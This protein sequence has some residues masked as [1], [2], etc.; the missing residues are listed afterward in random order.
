MRYQYTIQRP[1]DSENEIEQAE[2]LWRFGS[3]TTCTA[4]CGTGESSRASLH[5]GAR[6]G[7]EARLSPSNVTSPP[8]VP[9]LFLTLGN[10]NADGTLWCREAAGPVLSLCCA[11]RHSRHR[12]GGWW[13]ELHVLRATLPIAA[14][15]E[16]CWHLAYKFLG[17]WFL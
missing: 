2:F 11:V 14:V 7:P 3:W 17:L 15:S 13:Q 4:T 10:V 6:N 1:A 9:S 12:R 16:H 8:L 5:H